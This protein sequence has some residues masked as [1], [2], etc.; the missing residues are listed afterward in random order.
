M[1]H[2]FFTYSSVDGHLGCFHVLTIVISAAM[3]IGVHVSF[4]IMVFSGYMPRSG[5]AGSYGSSAFS[6][7]FTLIFTFTHS[8]TEKET[9]HL[10][11]SWAYSICI[12]TLARWISFHLSCF[13]FLFHLQVLNSLLLWIYMSFYQVMTTRLFYRSNSV[14]Q[15]HVAWLHTLKLS[16]ISY[17]IT[18]LL[19]LWRL[20]RK[21]N[22]IV[23]DYLGGFVLYCSLFFLMGKMNLNVRRSNFH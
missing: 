4:W 6:F 1:Y 3:N 20:S 5:I 21:F 16:S 19:R 10:A 14:E 22:S 13:S 15:P 9:H 12:Y 2:I 18:Q 7:L 8:L 17:I 23:L 11:Q